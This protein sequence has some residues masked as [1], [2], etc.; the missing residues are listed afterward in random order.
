MIA[1]SSSPCLANI[2]E[3][4]KWFF[5]WKEGVQEDNGNLYNITTHKLN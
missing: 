5:K 1:S 2:S 4:M 3:G